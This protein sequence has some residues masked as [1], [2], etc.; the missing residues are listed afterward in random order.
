MT[1]FNKMRSRRLDRLGEELHDAGARAFCSTGIELLKEI[2]RARFP[3]RHERRFP[4]YGAI[5]SA[6]DDADI[7]QRL[8]ALGAT[9]LVGQRESSHLVREMADGIQSFA[10]IRADSAELVLLP[11]AIPREVELVRLQRSLGPESTL[12]CRSADGIVKVVEHDQN[13]IFDGTR[14]WTK[15]D[16]HRYAALVRAEVPGA[17]LDVAQNILDFCVHTAGPAAGGT[18]LVWC[19]REDAIDAIHTSSLRTHPPLAFDVPMTTPEAHSALQH[20]L[21]QVDGAATVDRIGNVIEIGL[22]LHPSADSHMAVDVS[23]VTGT[24]HAAAQLCSFDVPDSLF[25]VV[26]DDGPVT[27]FA[28]GSVVAS[29]REENP[30]VQPEQRALIVSASRLPTGDSRLVTAKDYGRLSANNSK[31]AV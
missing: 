6:G 5:V 26:S 16:S 21:S 20:L 8:D 25:F 28:R 9:R 7:V 3:R 19:L 4:G 29:I 18:I 13:L 17:P 23:P 14:W 12:V 24:R 15:P 30:T 22:H 2:D 10:L 27:V 31:G 1:D 11:S